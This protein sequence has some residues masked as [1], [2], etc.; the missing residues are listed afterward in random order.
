MV[1]ALHAIDAIEASVSLANDRR[2]RLTREGDASAGAPSGEE[3]T[4]DPAT[5][6]IRA[7]EEPIEFP[8]LA[9]GTVPG[10][11]VAVALADAVPNAGEVVRGAVEA[12]LHAGIEVEAISVVTTDAAT[13]QICQEALAAHAEK[14]P[15]F[16]VHDPEDDDNLCLVGATKRGEALLV[17]RIIFD[18]DIVLP[19]GVA[20]VDGAGAYDSLFPWFCDAASIG[21]LRMPASAGAVDDSRK[22][23]TAD[24]AGW[25]IGAPLV[26]QVVPGPG[27]SVAHVV[28]GEPQAAAR[29]CDELCRRR[30]LLHSPRQVD[31]AIVTITGDARSQTWANV[32]RA[33]AAAD[34]VLADYGAIAICT[35]LEVP[36]GESLGRLI[37]SAD[38]EK[39]VRKI[40]H[41]QGEDSWPAWHLARA[42]RR[43]PVYLLSQLSAETVEDLGLAPIADLVELARLAGRHESFV[44]IEDSQHAVVAVDC[45]E[46][47]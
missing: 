34:R 39:T 10:D 7:L 9:A 27:E 18:A 6:V 43:G 14:L 29:R 20:R 21:R 4:C 13:A 30:W 47:E 1:K 42:L 38:L 33:V 3:S 46:D 24:E 25:L 2:V 31:L 8:P 26:L 37:G 28:A 36:P 45:E 11:R 40:G 15:Q 17:N 32:G 35:N 44:V 23:H 5:A 16:V 12:I 22:A 19:I 41:D